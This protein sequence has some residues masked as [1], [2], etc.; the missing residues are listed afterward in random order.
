MD[1]EAKKAI[2]ELKE[3]LQAITT[4]MFFGVVFTIL[5]LI[6]ILILW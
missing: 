2:L 1:D 6:V 3:G 4:Q 5:L